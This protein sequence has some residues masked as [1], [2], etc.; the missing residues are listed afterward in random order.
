MSAI[1]F[2]DQ[3]EN[4]LSHFALLNN[5]SFLYFFNKSSSILLDLILLDL[6]NPH[7]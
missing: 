6:S 5:F 1:S 7:C 4:L 2:Y 3:Q